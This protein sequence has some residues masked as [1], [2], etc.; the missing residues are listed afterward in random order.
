MSK[1]KFIVRIRKQEINVKLVS[2]KLYFNIKFKKCVIQ[3]IFIKNKIVWSNLII[4][5][6]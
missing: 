2:S 1:V 6:I 3:L 5:I 4:I